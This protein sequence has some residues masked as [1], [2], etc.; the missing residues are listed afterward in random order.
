MPVTSIESLDNPTD[1]NGDA[2][3]MPLPGQM[4]SVAQGESFFDGKAMARVGVWLSSYLL[5][6][7]TLGLGTM[8]AYARVVRWDNNIPFL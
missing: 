8:W 1:E 4:R 2:I 7:I 5:V 3:Q 6:I